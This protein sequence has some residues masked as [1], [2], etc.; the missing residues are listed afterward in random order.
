MNF[1][2][3]KIVARIQFQI[4]FVEIERLKLNFYDPHQY[5]FFSEDFHN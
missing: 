2:V 3:N 1:E 5:I 4:K